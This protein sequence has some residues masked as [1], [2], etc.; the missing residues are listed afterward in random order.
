[1]TDNGFNDR[2]RNYRTL[3]GILIAGISGAGSRRPRARLA[4]LVLTAFVVDYENISDNRL[5]DGFE[6]YVDTAVVPCSR[7]ATD[8][9]RVTPQ[10]THASRRTADWN[11]EPH[12]RIGNMRAS[13]VSLQADPRLL[14]KE[15]CFPCKGLGHLIGRVQRRGASAHSP[16]KRFLLHCMVTNAV[17]RH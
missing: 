11:A 9:M 7:K 2:S 14:S 8:P 13:A 1:M 15:E 5:I 6:K 16:W 12:V 3:P 4:F 17:E 10:G